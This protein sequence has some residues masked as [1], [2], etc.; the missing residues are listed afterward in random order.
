MFSQLYFIPGTRTLPIANKIYF[1]KSRRKFVELKIFKFS[2]L[3]HTLRGKVRRESR[4]WGENRRGGGGERTPP[5]RS[6]VLRW[7]PIQF[8]SRPNSASLNKKKRVLPQYF[9]Q[10]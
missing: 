2:A 10:I 3:N 9:L 4:G 7:S 1:D 8:L 5:T 6:A